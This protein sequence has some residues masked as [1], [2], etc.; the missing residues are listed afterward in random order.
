MRVG[1]KWVGKLFE[2]EPSR[3]SLLLGIMTP[4]SMQI[5]QR[6]CC[7]MVIMTL[8]ALQKIVRLL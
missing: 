3:Q 8:F 2:V 7:T 5:L 1:A 6:L 4:W